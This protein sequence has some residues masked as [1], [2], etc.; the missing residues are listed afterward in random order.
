MFTDAINQAVALT[1]F[2][3][4]IVEKDYYVTIIL[5]ELAD[6]LPFVVFK[7]GSSLSKCYKVIDRYSEDIDISIDTALSQG[8][9]R[10]L[11]E[12]LKNITMRMGLEIPNIEDTRSRRDFN[13]YFIHYAPVFLDPNSAI[14]PDVQL[15]TS[16]TE[17]SFPV[18]SMEVHSF[19]GDMLATEA[20]DL[21]KQYSL[22]PFEMKVQSIDRTMIDKVFAICDYY[23]GKKEIDKHSRHIYDIYKLL[24]LVPDNDDYRKLIKDV[25]EERLK[26]KIC[27][28]VQ[29][30]VN[31]PKLL[32]EIVDN[33]IYKYGYDNLT[34]YLL[35]DKISY[36]EAISAVKKIIE[37]EAFE[38]NNG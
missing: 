32:Q 10:K 14:N 5:R 18:V 8:Q 15:E 31:V 7:G 16:F 25:R 38:E 30:G 34:Y 36:E 26:A 22:E 20:P 2:N 21:L 11:K 23:L 35:K 19:I 6:E 12:A 4:A 33:K 13:K 17:I 28:S 24:P 3:P 29:P 9:K 1:G 27:L 37:S